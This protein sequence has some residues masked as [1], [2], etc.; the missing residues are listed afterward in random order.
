VRD[1]PLARALERGRERYNAL[2]AQASGGRIDVEAF[3]G[4]LRDVIGPVAEAVDRVR[5]DRVDAVVAAAYDLSLQ[6]FVAGLLGPQ[7][8]HPSIAAAWLPNVPW[9]LADEPLA[10]TG[11]VTNAV[12]NL[13]TH[14]GARPEIWIK[15]M[16]AVSGAFSDLAT[17][18]AAG[19]V[20][21]WRCGMAQHRAGALASCRT[22][23][24]ALATR[25]LGVPDFDPARFG[26]LLDRL[27][28]DPWL[29]PNKA[30]D[31]PSELRVVSIV[32]AFRGFGGHFQTPPTVFSSNG[33]IIAADRENHW[34]VIADLWGSALLP[35]P[36][37]PPRNNNSQDYVLSRDGAVDSGGLRAAFPGLAAS[38]S[39]ACDGRTLAVTIGQSHQIFLIARQ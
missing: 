31:A 12:Y 3:K 22:L 26:D 34:A 29:A 35:L 37:A 36:S 24:P 19:H 7:S 32:G 14:E 1:A 17:L 33:S 21:A 15:E 20:L 30:F 25:L 9:L 23:Q 2:F 8:R 4:H 28:I 6:L 18:R 16:A 38:T 39:S 27:S 11:S 10:V 5:Q 13:S